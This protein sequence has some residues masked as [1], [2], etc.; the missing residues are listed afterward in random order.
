MRHYVKMKQHKL[1]IPYRGPYLVLKRVDPTHYL[2]Q[3]SQNSEKIN[4]HVDQIGK[5]YPAKDET[6]INWSVAENCA[7][8]TV[9]CQ[10][11]GIVGNP[12]L[13]GVPKKAVKRPG[14]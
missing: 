2:I 14:N 7:P 5:Y 6:L 1:Q 9:A 4:V 3:Q 10:T 12:I 8:C 13:T 11:E